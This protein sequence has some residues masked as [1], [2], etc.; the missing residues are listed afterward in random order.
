MTSESLYRNCTNCKNTVL[1]SAKNCPQCGTK[2]KKDVQILKYIGI[3]LL[4]WIIIAGVMTKPEDTRSARPDAKDGVSKELKLD[5][6][7]GTDGFGMVM[8]ANFTIHNNSDRAIKDVQ[9]KCQHYA[10]SGTK[11]D[12]NTEVIYEVIKAN[13]KQSFRDVNMGFIR[14][15]VKSSFCGIDKFSVVQ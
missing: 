3:A 15:Q 1:K 10:N 5:F 8:K 6:S 7:W 9:I 4:A 14:D 11:I 12:Q 13:S 2:Q